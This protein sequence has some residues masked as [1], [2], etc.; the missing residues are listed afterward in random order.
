MTRKNDDIFSLR[1]IAIERNAARE[2]LR[3]NIAETK[4]RVK[5][6]N[7]MREA[8]DNALNKAQDA[9]KTAVETVKSNPGITASVIAAAAALVTLRKPLTR[10]IA[11]RT[12]RQSPDSEE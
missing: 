8:K 7:L 4:E 5:P 3:D 6:K 12:T 2:N 11:G 1:E 9:G 10:L